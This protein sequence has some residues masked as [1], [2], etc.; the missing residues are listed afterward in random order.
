MDPKEFMKLLNDA[1]ELMIQE[2]YTE[3]MEILENL[4]EIDKTSEIDY[5]YDLVHQLYQLDSNCKSAHHQ[6]IILKVLNEIKIKKNSI[7]LK[8]L[9][10]VL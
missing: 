8:D 1:R 4:K 2:K 7:S 10:S 6:Q 3:A 9:N 5:N